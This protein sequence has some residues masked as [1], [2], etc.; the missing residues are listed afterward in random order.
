MFNKGKIYGI[1][2]FGNVFYYWNLL[3]EIPII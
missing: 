2:D 3:I 1:V